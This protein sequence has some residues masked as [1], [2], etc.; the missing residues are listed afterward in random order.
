MKKVIGVLLFGLSLAIF[1]QEL[2]PNGN[3]N[4]V[5]NG[6]A[7]LWMGNITVEKN[8]PEGM[9]SAEIKVS[10]IPSYNKNIRIATIFNNRIRNLAPG[11]YQLNF[12]FKG[13]ALYC[14]S[15]QLR[16]FSKAPVWNE[17]ITKDMPEPDKWKFF[18]FKFELKDTLPL[19]ILEFSCFA[20]KKEENASAA[21]ADISLTCMNDS[22]PPGN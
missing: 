15:V 1:A 5:T 14:M 8:L 3:F 16:P 4:D 12:K 6:K 17:K 21:F 13:K 11:I 19:G 22:V 10:D 7:N 2:L 9:N 18:S 20:M